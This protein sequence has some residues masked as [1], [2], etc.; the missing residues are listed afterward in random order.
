M[1]F[2]PGRRGA[3]HRAMPGMARMFGQRRSQPLLLGLPTIR[4]TRRR[5]AR[6]KGPMALRATEGDEDGAEGGLQPRSPSG[7][8][9]PRGLKSALRTAP[10]VPRVVSR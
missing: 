7:T 4:S 1:F 5:T 6:I 8:E 9:V 3:S 10:L 2:N